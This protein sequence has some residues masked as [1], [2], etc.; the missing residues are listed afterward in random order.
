MKTKRYVKIIF[1]KQE[2]TRIHIGRSE[3]EIVFD[4]PAENEDQNDSRLIENPGGLRA[5]LKKKIREIWNRSR[6]RR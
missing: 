3:S 1:E 4:E 6:H 2:I 5:R